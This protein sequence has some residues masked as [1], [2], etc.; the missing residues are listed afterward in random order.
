MKLFLVPVLP[1]FRTQWK[2][3]TGARFWLQPEHHLVSENWRLP[4]REG[5]I[6]DHWSNVPTLFKAR[7]LTQKLFPLILKRNGQLAVCGL[8]LVKTSDILDADWQRWR[9]EA[10]PWSPEV[11]GC[12]TL[13]TQN[14]LSSRPIGFN[15]DVFAEEKMVQI[16]QKAKKA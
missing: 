14:S 7:K 16:I 1:L 11:I 3:L 2:P 10:I 9:K 6:A 13:A 4:Y 5:G 8:W 12:L 15:Q